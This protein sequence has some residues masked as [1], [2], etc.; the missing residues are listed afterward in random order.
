MKS[1]FGGKKIISILGALALTFAFVTK[2]SAASP[3]DLVG[4]WKLD[5]NEEDSSTN[6]LDGNLVGNEN[7]VTHT[8]F[9][10][11]HNFDGATYIEVADNPLL[12]PVDTLTVEAWVKRSGSPGGAKYIVSKYLPDRFGSYSSYG[13]YSGS[14]GLRFYVGNTSGWTASPEATAAQVWNDTWH[15]VAGTF[16]GANVKLFVDGIQVPGSGSTVSDIYYSGTGNLYIGSYYNGTWLAFTGLIDDVRIWSKAL[17]FP[18][19]VIFDPKADEVYFGI[20][21]LRAFFVDGNSTSSPVNWAVRY[22]TCDANTN[23]RF[24][25]VDGHSDLPNWDGSNFSAEINTSIVDPG[26]YCFVFNPGSGVRETRWFY[27]GKLGALSP[28]T[29]Y[30]P[31]GT[32][33]T[34][35]TNIGV[36][37]AGVEV[38]FFVDG[39]NPLATGTDET[40]T[41][42]KAEFTYPGNNPG[43][44][45]ITA[46]IDQNNND[47]CDTGE[48]ASTTT[49]TKYWL[50][51][52]VTGGGNVKDSNG[53]KVIWTFGGNAGYFPGSSE[54]VGQFQLV[55]HPDKKVCHFNDFSN[56]EFSG[57]KA[58]NPE[59][60][61]NTVSFIANGMCNGEPVP[62]EG[63]SFV[64]KDSGEPG[65]NT[66]EIQ[67]YGLGVSLSGRI[68]EG[69]FQVHDIE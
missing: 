62:V 16:D 6:N 26:Y 33:H 53:R 44:D 20:T 55:Y 8:G 68:S 13:L 2:V 40:D 69:N 30:N 45:T 21:T 67:V 54:P 25:N 58:T 64:I 49:S 46:C 15:H 39:A 56:F 22:N 23:T 18:Y 1:A 11:A 29:A 35:S 66:D 32:T 31:V 4:W 60:P 37:V 34:V 28:E 48:P 50:A 38:L 3:D 19:G 7:Y 43:T 65:A 51:E 17:A 41:T 24:G 10:Y 5:Q 27:I 42:G 12:E 14:G 57:E 61:Y 47:E 63:V 52:Y 9:G 36:P 59:A